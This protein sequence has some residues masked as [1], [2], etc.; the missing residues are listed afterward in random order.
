MPVSPWI[1]PESV[2][3]FPYQFAVEYPADSNN[4]YD[5]DK[6]HFILTYK[7]SNNDH[8]LYLS[9][10]LQELD[11][12]NYDHDYNT[13]PLEWL[14]GNYKILQ[15]RYKTDIVP[16]EPSYKRLTHD[17][18]YISIEFKTVDN[19]D[20]IND[21]SIIHRKYK[22]NPRTYS[23]YPSSLT[24]EPLRES[25]FVMQTINGVEESIKI[26]AYLYYALFHPLV[27]NMPDLNE[28]PSPMYP[29]ASVPVP[30]PVP[31]PVADLLPVSAP[32]LGGVTSNAPNE[33][34]EPFEPL[35]S[36]LVGGPGATG[37]GSAAAPSGGA[38]FSR[39]NRK[40][41]RKARKSRK[42][43]KSNTRRRR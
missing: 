29:S 6:Q 4:N 3:P 30:V 5:E 10:K 19:P 39:R 24:L 27:E 35:A 18:R 43:R 42:S 21:F 36:E 15:I 41:R 31:A 8:G 14:E 28:Q 38:G 2:V 23:Y 12:H 22:P 13:D 16:A 25:F 1:D 9:Y 26:D 20:T 33:P 37:G 11:P 7:E 34:Y 40:S 32:V 17:D